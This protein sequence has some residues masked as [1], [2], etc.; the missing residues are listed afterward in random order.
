MIKIGKS[1]ITKSEGKAFLRSKIE[2]DCEAANGWKDFSKTTPGDYYLYE[3]YPPRIWEDEDFNLYFSVDEEHEESLCSDRNDAFLVGMIVYAIASGSDIYSDAPISKSLLKGI[4]EGLIPNFCKG[5][6]NGF[7]PIEIIADDIE[8][9]KSTKGFVSTG[10]TCGVDSMYALISNLGKITHL[11]YFDVGEIFRVPGEN[12]EVPLIEYRK[13]VKEAVRRKR[14]KAREVAEECNFVFLFIDSNLDRDIYR[15][16]YN[17]SCNYRNVSCIFATAN[18]WSEYISAS[19]G[20]MEN[21][22]EKEFFSIRNDPAHYLVFLLESLST[23]ACKLSTDKTVDRWV[24]TNVIADNA[25]AQK[26][27]DVC[28]KECNCGTCPKCVRTMLMLEKLDK[29][30]RFKDALN[31]SAYEKNEKQVIGRVI[32]DK[33]RNKD[34]YDLYKIAKEM[35]KVSF[36]SYIYALGLLISRNIYFALK[37]VIPNINKTKIYKVTIK[38]FRQ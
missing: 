11:V 19:G 33:F 26:Y 2:I 36:I 37:K 32:F 18:Y 1:Y 31:I 4:R 24:K 27:L 10:M 7:R 23:S 35:N 22:D 38:F 34:E 12:R 14:D 28:Y 25:I 30:D 15:G 29:L 9:L 5:N 17:C 20:F 8:D 6:E 21:P 16:G 13:Y 3:D